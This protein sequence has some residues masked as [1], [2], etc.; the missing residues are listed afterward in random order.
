MIRWHHFM[1]RRH[2]GVMR[3]HDMSTRRD[4]MI[5]HDMMT[6][7]VLTLTVP[8]I[9][10]YLCGCVAHVRQGGGPRRSV[11]LCSRRS[12]LPRKLHMNPAGLTYD[13]APHRADHLLSRRF[14][15]PRKLH[16][17]PAGAVSDAAP[18]DPVHIVYRRSNSSRSCVYRARCLLTMQPPCGRLFTQQSV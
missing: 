10:L 4:M 17:H 13:P 18:C 5:C 3:C 12:I 1:T 8:E 7:V 16:L 2:H 14:N 6:I 11:H 9:F 15:S